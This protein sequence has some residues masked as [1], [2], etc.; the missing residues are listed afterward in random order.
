RGM[1][2]ASAAGN[3]RAGRQKSYGFMITMQAHVQRFGQAGQIGHGRISS[4][5][6]GDPGPS[7]RGP[8]LPKAG[9]NT[10]FE[11]PGRAGSRTP[12]A[13]IPPS[14]GIAGVLAL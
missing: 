7:E 1:A 10:R 2:V 5:G 14:A 9:E 4:G 13:Q 3:G 6:R 8:L 12:G 11:L